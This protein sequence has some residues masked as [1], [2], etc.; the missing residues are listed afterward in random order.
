MGGNDQHAR[1]VAERESL[2]RE[3]AGLTEAKSIALAPRGLAFAYRAKVAW[4][5]SMPRDKSAEVSSPS[6]KSPSRSSS[7]AAKIPRSCCPRASSERVD[8]AFFWDTVPGAGTVASSRKARFK[9]VFG[10]LFKPAA[11]AKTDIGVQK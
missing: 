7:K 2:G 5:G 4:V 10:P 8:E 1:I 11:E 9:A 6:F 3:A